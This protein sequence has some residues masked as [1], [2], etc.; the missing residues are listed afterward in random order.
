MGRAIEQEIWAAV[1]MATGII[2]IKP[3]ASPW[4]KSLIPQTF[5]IDAV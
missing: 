1:F 3:S 5:P 2:K 4:R